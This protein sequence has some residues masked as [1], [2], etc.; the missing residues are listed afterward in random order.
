[1]LQERE[2]G[3]SVLVTFTNAAAEEL[4]SRLGGVIGKRLRNAGP[5]EVMT[6]HSWALDLLRKSGE[7]FRLL[8]EGQALERLPRGSPP[9]K[10]VTPKQLRALYTRLQR[11]KVRGHDPCDAAG[12]AAERNTVAAYQTWLT[13][14]QSG[15][16]ADVVL[17]A[18]AVAM[19]RVFHLLV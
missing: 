17:R 7:R 14:S 1:W 10:H 19:P 11:A 6:F 9:G 4:S 12:N 8:P 16:F 2:P 18:A 13:R 5:R 3:S 15:D